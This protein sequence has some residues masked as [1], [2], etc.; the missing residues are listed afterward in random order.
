MQESNVRESFALSRELHQEAS[1]KVTLP[2]DLANTHGGEKSLKAVPKLPET[3]S[4]SRVA[5]QEP[6][7]KHVCGAAQ[8][9]R[10]QQG[11]VSPGRGTCSPAFRLVTTSSCGRARISVHDLQVKGFVC[12]SWSPACA[13]G[14]PCHTAGL[15]SN[16][17]SVFSIFP[18][19]FGY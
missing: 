10:L 19:T 1:L 13:R 6:T 5:A 4:A 2:R 9:S 7:W 12:H 17:L 3:V 11:H 15:T 16:L 14:S 8:R 18:A